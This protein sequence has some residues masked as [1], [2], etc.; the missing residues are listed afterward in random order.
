[1]KYIIMC[2]GQYD[3]WKMPKQLLEI[4]GE[5][6]A[7]RTI[8]LL[9]ENGVRDIAISA[10][11]PLFRQLGVPVLKH[12]NE[13]HVYV[14]HDYAGDWVNGFYPMSEPVCYL[15][16][17]VVFSP[18]AIKKIVKAETDGIEFFAS[19][20]PFSPKY[21]KPWAEP[22][23]F[24]VADTERFFA[25]VEEVKRLHK[26]GVYKRAPIAWELWQA[27]IGGRPN[28]ID[29]GT[30]TVIND[31]TCDIDVEQDIQRMIQAMT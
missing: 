31:Y 8:R 23:A 24:K 3:R 10:D 5:P 28:E 21:S 2:G 1:M 7:G 30:Y 19:C 18:K 9:R 16:G 22:F 6:I 12:E 26:E 27:I 29:Y 20:P 17:D 4:N 15:L 14:D 25:A 13:W 11:D